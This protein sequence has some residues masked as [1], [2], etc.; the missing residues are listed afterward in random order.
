MAVNVELAKEEYLPSIARMWRASITSTG[1][2]YEKEDSET[3]LL[4][5]LREHWPD[6]WDLRVVRADNRIIAFLA[7]DVRANVLAQIFVAPER[8]REG[9]GTALLQL[10]KELM[11]DRIALWTDSRN[12]R[13]RN[14][15]EHEGFRL[16]REVKHPSAAHFRAHYEWCSGVR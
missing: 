16:L 4:A 2:R 10:A 13:A 7:C 9:I 3:D 12:R 8:Q 5:K 11:P 1:I 15:Y 6:R 14:F